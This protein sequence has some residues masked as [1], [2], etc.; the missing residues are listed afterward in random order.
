MQQAQNRT[1]MTK[2][3]MFKTS[4][5]FFFCFSLLS[6]SN[7]AVDTSSKDTLS[8][9]SFNN[10]NRDSNHKSTQNINKDSTQQTCK[11]FAKI[12]D[13]E[14][15]NKATIS[16]KDSSF[17]VE[18]NKYSV[19]Q[20]FGYERPDTTSKKLLLISCF[21][22]DVEDNPYKCKYGAFYTTYNM[23]SFEIKFVAK[24]NDFVK[25]K[26]LDKEQII[27]NLFFEKRFV[28]FDN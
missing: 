23:D 9:D 10:F 13:G 21:T 25:C 6:C 2:R 14:E 16:L 22:Y 12:V 11:E 19:H 20:I 5:I 18:S 24:T 28:E 27:A 4:T 3:K 15:T 7:N 17:I 1:F 8:K 26:L